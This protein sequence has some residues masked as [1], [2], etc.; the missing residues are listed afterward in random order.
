MTQNAFD[1]LGQNTV[2]KL[3]IEHHLADTFNRDLPQNRVFHVKVVLSNQ[4]E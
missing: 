3:Q 4:S 2:A 1:L